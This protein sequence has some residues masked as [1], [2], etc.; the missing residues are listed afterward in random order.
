MFNTIRDQT[1][2]ANSQSALLLCQGPGAGGGGG[3]GSSSS[4]VLT[5]TSIST[6]ES[7][8]T[9]T[10]TSTSSSLISS[11]F[12]TRTG[13]TGS[14]AES[15]YSGSGISP[16]WVTRDEVTVAHLGESSMNKFGQVWSSLHEQNDASKKHSPHMLSCW[17]RAF[18]P[19]RKNL[20]GLKV[21]S[22]QNYT[23]LVQQKY[24]TWWI[25]VRRP[26]DN[27]E[28]WEKKQK[29][30]AS[31]NLSSMWTATSPSSK[32]VAMMA[33][34]RLNWKR[35]VTCV[36]QEL[37]PLSWIT[38]VWIRFI[39]VLE[40]QCWDIIAFCGELFELK[41]WRLFNFKMCLD[42]L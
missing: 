29:I 34:W 33:A 8:L 18:G 26:I 11:C 41:L 17:P 16:P 25:H 24:K 9:S 14:G 15:S 7:L 28:N 1:V 36:K 40:C 37:N 39:T 3:G 42:T 22:I 20:T 12:L 19:C 10:S 32:A 4:S 35:M 13:P 6:S 31:K 27:I 23:W 2:C 21:M 30:Y 5:S 38:Y